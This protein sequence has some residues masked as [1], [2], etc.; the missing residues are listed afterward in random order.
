[1]SKFEPRVFWRTLARDIVVAGQTRIEGTWKAYIGTTMERNHED[2]VPEIL[3][4]GTAVHEPLARAIFPHFKDV[5]YS[6]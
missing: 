6:Q 1:M 4:R 2:A 5:P 3:M